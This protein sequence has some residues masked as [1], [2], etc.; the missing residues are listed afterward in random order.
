MRPAT[1]AAAPIAVSSLADARALHPGLRVI[2]VRSSAA[3][4]AG[5]P[6]DAGHCPSESFGA[7]RMELPARLVP[8]FVVHDEAALAHEAATQLAHLGFERVTWLERALADEPAGHASVAPPARLWSPS[9]FLERVAPT[10]RAGRAL[11]LA[12]GSGRAAVYLALAGFEVEAWDLD[13]SALALAEAFAT[14]HGVRLTTRE[15]DLEGTTPVLPERGFDVIIVIRY[16]HRALFPWIERALAPGG[17]L[18]YETF[19][20]GQEQ[21]G[22]PRRDRHLLEPGELRTAFPMLRTVFHEEDDP[23]APPVLARLLAKHPADA[24]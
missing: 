1:E 7:R 16:L 15:C 11:D 8:V 20:R 2:D 6:P 18:V 14:R 3:F 19:R 9:P 4:A 10:L 17:T 23:A 12:C 22:H 21:F 24:D 5:H 13:P